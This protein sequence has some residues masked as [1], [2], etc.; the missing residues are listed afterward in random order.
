MSEQQVLEKLRGHAA[1]VAGHAYAP[2]SRFPVG[3]AV[4]GASG[5]V[6]TGCNVEN[7]S[8]SL[9]QCAERVAL[10]A[11]IA[12]GNEP[13]SIAALVLYTPGLRVHS[14]CGACRQVMHELMAPGGLVASCCD[15]EST[16]I[17]HGSEHL[18]E[19]FSPDA[20][21]RVTEAD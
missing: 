7:A 11:A 2:Y 1:R 15:G 9:T 18:P 13:G 8:F 6:Y 17:W 16:R 5:R 10:A 21:R 4:L 20:L 19:A 3:A 14:P 12:D